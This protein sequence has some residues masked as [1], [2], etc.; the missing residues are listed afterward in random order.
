MADSNVSMCDG[1]GDYKKFTDFGLNYMILWMM[2]VMPQPTSTVFHRGYCCTYMSKDK[3][4][5]FQKSKKRKATDTV[6]MMTTRSHSEVAGNSV[7]EIKHDHCIFCGNKC[8]PMNHK[9]RAVF[10][11][12]VHA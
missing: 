4:Y 6:V 5:R 1:G 12:T 11:Y 9:Y 10:V 8:L 7:F 3:I 2:V